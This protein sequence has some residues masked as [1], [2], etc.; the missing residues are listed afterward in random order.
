MNKP[1]ENRYEFIFLFDC[2]NGNPNGDPDA[3][4]APRIDPQDMRGLVSD[5][6]LKRRIRNYVQLAKGNQVPNA[7]FVEHATNLNRPIAMAHAATAGGISAEGKGAAKP[8]VEMA[9]QWMCQNFYDVRAFGAVMSTGLNAGHVRGPVQLTFARSV[10][11]VLPLD[12][13]I[14]RM[15]VAEDVKGAKTVADLTAWEEKQPEETLRTMGRK[16]LIPYGL[17]VAKGFISANLA[18][19]T[20][21]TEDDLKLLWQAILNMYEHDRSSSKGLMTVH[22]EHAYCFKHVGTDGDA[23]QRGREDSAL[24]VGGIPRGR[25]S[26]IFGPESSGKTTLALQVVGEAQR[27]GG[28]AAFID[29][30]HAIDP[31]YAKSLG[32]DCDRLLISQP[33]YGEE[34]LEIAAR[35]IASGEM[36]VVVVDSVAALI[37]KAE[38]EGAM[39]YETSGSARLMS[40]ALRKLV[41]PVH[42]TGTCLIF[43]NQI[44][45]KVGVMFGNPETA[46]GGRAL[47]HYAS[48]RLELR[49]LN[50]IVEQESIVGAR[51]R[52]RVVKNKAASPHGKAEFDLI[53]D[54]GISREGELIDLGVAQAI[55][56]QIGCDFHY[57][58]KH[59]GR[60]REN[61]RRFLKDNAD[62]RQAIR[63]D[64]HKPKMTAA[65]GYTPAAGGFK[66]F[67]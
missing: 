56:E 58:S 55:I 31:A 40:H 36:G 51:I 8:K 53:Y 45:D 66:Y 11:P 43:T 60:G 63:S 3:A 65:G 49:R 33:A 35:L 17:Y 21:F 5:V 13:S 29:L 57:K 23:G 16:S 47:R 64:I 62:I 61:V 20:G 6:A 10:D 24:G 14:T 27:L 59:L 1:I 52:A 34:A 38:F 26:E 54:E 37:P 18:E 44:R 28:G 22:G 42:R 19:Q 12:I 9:R 2:E 50:P 7:I 48:V 67:V 4:N 41:A 30:E 25:I 32:V 46:A 15:A 39:G